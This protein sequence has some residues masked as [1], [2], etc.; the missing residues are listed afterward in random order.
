MWKISQ[1]GIE[2][3]ERWSSCRVIQKHAG[4]DI[5]NVNYSIYNGARGI[6]E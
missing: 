1:M 6:N 3:H 5:P 4:I 2:E